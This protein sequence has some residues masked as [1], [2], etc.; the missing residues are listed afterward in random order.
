MYEIENNTFWNNNPC[1]SFFN[2]LKEKLDTNGECVKVSALIIQFRA[3]SVAICLTDN[4][5]ERLFFLFKYCYSL[6]ANN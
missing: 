1:I 3:D 5:F 4:S 6:S 2:L